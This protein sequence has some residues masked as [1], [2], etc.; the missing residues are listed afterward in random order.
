MAL[1]EPAGG[2][3]GKSKLIDGHQGRR[4]SLRTWDRT[5][6]GPVT[7]TS[8]AFRERRPAAM[9]R[10]TRTPGR[11]D[12]RSN[13]RLDIGSRT[14]EAEWIRENEREKRRPLPSWCISRRSSRLRRSGVG[15]HSASRTGDRSPVALLEESTTVIVWLG[16]P[17]PARVRRTSR[18]QSATPR[19]CP[20]WHVCDG[21]LFYFEAHPATIPTG[22][23]IDGTHPATDTI[24]TV[25]PS[26]AWLA[27]MAGYCKTSL[28]AG[29][30]K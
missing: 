19:H 2:V 6:T 20:R 26:E 25:A 27:E 21:L 23:A 15:N 17:Q 1:R 14:V 16:I 3:R 18:S 8:P 12:R 30:Y 22:S 7:P 28:Q 24:K 10:R 11:A 5:G 9:S 29:G 13:A 4:P